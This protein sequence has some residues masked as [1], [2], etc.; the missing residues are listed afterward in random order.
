M[1]PKRRCTERTKGLPTERMLRSPAWPL[2]RPLRAAAAPAKPAAPPTPSRACS[3]N[4]HAGFLAITER[5]RAAPSTHVAPTAARPSAALGSTV[6]EAK[7]SAPTCSDSSSSSC[8]RDRGSAW[9]NGPSP[10]SSLRR[11]PRAATHERPCARCTPPGA[12]CTSSPTAPAASKPSA[13]R[14]P[15]RAEC[16]PPRAP[17]G[18]RH[19]GRDRE[20]IAAWARHEERTVKKQGHPGPASAGPPPRVRGES[21]RSPQRRALA[22]L[23]QAP[24]DDH[25]RALGHFAPVGCHPD[26]TRR[27]QLQA[28]GRAP[29]GDRFAL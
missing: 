21:P 26:V 24:P 9:A 2:R 16:P 15:R 6:G 28:C 11:P 4:R 27:A 7:G 13:G 20:A 17:G 18:P 19:G 3:R 29:R 1:S 10:P 25:P 14:G 22:H 12:R 23:R 5:R 8:P